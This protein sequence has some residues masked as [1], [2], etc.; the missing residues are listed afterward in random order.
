MQNK[1]ILLFVI[2]MLSS[3]MLFAQTESTFTPTIKVKALVHSRFEASLTDSVDVQNKFLADRVRTNFRMRRIELRTDIKLNDKFSGV[4]RIQLP[5]LKGSNIGRTIELAYMEFKCKD[6]FQI[7]AGQ[8]KLPYE[9]DELTSHEDLRMIDR[10]TTSVLFVN[11]S[12]ASYQ[13][14]IMIFG[15][16]FKETTPLNY[17]LAAVNGSNRAV[18]Y[19]DNSQ[20]NLA[21]RLEYSFIKGIRLGVN[22]QYVA[23]KDTSSNSYGVDLSIQKNI[24]PKTKLIVEGEYIKGISTTS[25]V[26]DTN[27]ISIDEFAMGGYFGQVLFKIDINKTW[28]KTFEI[29]GKFE[30]TDPNTTVDANDFTTI[31]GDIGFTFLPDNTARLQLNIVNTKWASAISPGGID[32]SNIFLAQ[33]QL[34]I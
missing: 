7:R 24:T 8:F 12:L 22:G 32:S 10:G 1:P 2:A 20:K 15:N 4:V 17:Y 31:T 6:G 21:A 18:N 33:F 29:G 30:N 13:P 25:F 5:E 11:N 26:L 16:F 14:G 28:C 3:V 23:I 9:L 19:D 34:K 27:E